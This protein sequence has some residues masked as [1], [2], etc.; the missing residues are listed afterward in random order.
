MNKVAV[1]ILAA[2]KGTRM[3]SKLAKVLHQVANKPMLEHVL[4]Q[5]K[6]VL[7]V[8]QKI[9]VVGHQGEDLLEILDDDCEVAWQREQRGTGHAVQKAIELLAENVQTVL[10]VCGDT[11]LLTAETLNSL[12]TFHHAQNA[13]ATV[14][15][16]HLGDATGYGRIIRDKE[17]NLEKIVEQKDATDKEKLIKEIN[18]GVYVF[19]ARELK[20]YLSELKS[21][22][23]QKEYYLTDIISILRKEQKSVKAFITKDASDII[24]IN[25]RIQLAEAEKIM[26]KRINNYWMQKGVTMVDP[27]SVYID[28]DVLLSQ[29]VWIGQNTIIQGKSIVAEGVHLG[30]NTIIKDSMLG[31]DTYVEQS[32]VLQS[33]IGRNCKIGPYAYIR[34]DCS[35]A[36]NVKVGD[37]SE[38]KN[39][40]VAEGSKIPHLSYI[41][42]AEIGSKV[43]IGAGTITC[44]YDGKNKFKTIIEDGAFIGS[45]TNLVAPVLVARQAYIA[46]GSTIV[47]DVPEKA[48]GIARGKQRNIEDW[49]PNK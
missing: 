32:T 38:L 2:G 11:P 1:I 37:F 40:I 5:A 34:P 48:L 10:V 6:Q 12:I 7:D 17:E 30:P 26:R 18:S 35:L 41:G 20:A 15:T 45:N 44:N 42:D 24:G 13:A 46:A 33:K 21:N 47:E 3:Y 49:K 29:D 31:I 19:A 23:T 36:D 9:V 27:D 39:T 14:L 43:N 8:K 28:D 16:A 25:S 22:N 4:I